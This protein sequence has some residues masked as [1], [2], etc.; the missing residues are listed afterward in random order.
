MPRHIFQL[1]AT[2]AH[3]RP[4]EV[5]VWFDLYWGRLHWVARVRG[6]G[7]SHSLRG[8]VTTSVP[9]YFLGL[10]RELVAH[11]VVE[12]CERLA[13]LPRPAQ[14]PAPGL[15]ERI[16]WPHPDS[17]YVSPRTP[18]PRRP[19]ARPRASP[20]PTRTALTR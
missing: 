19:P 10:L 2:P 3:P 8:E 12:A 16:A 20:S 15:A 1:P 14:R 11:E 17:W 6:A 4:A 18:A 9:R 5:R 7:G 13:P